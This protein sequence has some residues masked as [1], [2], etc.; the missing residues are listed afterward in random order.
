MID[1]ALELLNMPMPSWQDD[2]PLRREL[3]AL[4]DDVRAYKIAS[5][6]DVAKAARKAALVNERA[7]RIKAFMR[8]HRCGTD[9]RR[10][11]ERMR[12]PV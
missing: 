2:A 11:W 12:T 5:G 1:D 10:F 9:A 7:D 4:R 8:G 6:Y 3:I